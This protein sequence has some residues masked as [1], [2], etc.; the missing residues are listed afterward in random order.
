M[1]YDLWLRMSRQADPLILQQELSLFRIHPSSKSGTQTAERFAE[2]YA[3]ARRYFNGRHSTR[4]L[5]WFNTQKI[6]WAYRLIAY[7]E[8]LSKKNGTGPII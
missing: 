3:V 7:A 8:K 4:F 2:Q 1:D 5:H 6:I